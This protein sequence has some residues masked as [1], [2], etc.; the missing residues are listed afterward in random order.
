M[1]PENHST[2]FPLR[3]V[4]RC[5]KISGGRIGN[6]GA[7]AA[8][9]ADCVQQDDNASSPQMVLSSIRQAS[10]RPSFTLLL[11]VSPISVEPAPM[12]SSSASLGRDPYSSW[13]S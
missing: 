6:G 2:A 9:E 4:F 12:V 3:V 11:N 10:G 8:D 5:R 7:D 13:P 1:K